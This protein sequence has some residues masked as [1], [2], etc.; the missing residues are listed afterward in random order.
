MLSAW[1]NSQK[2]DFMSRVVLVMHVYK[3]YLFDSLT[4]PSLN[5]AV[6]ES[7]FDSLTELQVMV[8][9]SEVT[10]YLTSRTRP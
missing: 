6:N 8:I 9:F 5:G 1:F 3:S 4:N 10:V 7:T 2:S